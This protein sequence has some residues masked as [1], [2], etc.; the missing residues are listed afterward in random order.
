MTHFHIMSL[1][2]NNTLNLC[3]LNSALSGMTIIGQHFILGAH[4]FLVFYYLV[5]LVVVVVRLVLIGH[6]AIQL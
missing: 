2:H 1:T 5:C 4:P 6:P 3:K